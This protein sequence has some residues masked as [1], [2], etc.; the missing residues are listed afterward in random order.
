MRHTIT[1]ADG[2][3]VWPKYP[4]RKHGWLQF[5]KIAKAKVNRARGK[6]RLR[7]NPLHATDR[8]PPLMAAL[9]PNPFRRILDLD[10]G[11]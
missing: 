8:A 9:A 7:Y 6:M 3:E 10:G 4:Q 11:A 2:R 1:L 5:F